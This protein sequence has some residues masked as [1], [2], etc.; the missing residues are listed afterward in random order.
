[1]V[2]LIDKAYFLLNWSG[3]GAPNLYP[4]SVGVFLDGLTGVNILLAVFNM[5]PAC[6]M[7]GGRILRGLLALKLDYARASAIAVFV[8]QGL[9]VIL[10][11]FRIFFNWRLALIGIFLYIGAGSEKQAVTLRSVLRQVHA[12]A[13][14]ETEIRTLRPEDFLSRPLEHIYRSWQD[15][16]QVF[17]DRG[18]EG[19]LARGRTLA[20][21]HEK[22][23]DI[24]VSE[25]MDRDFASIDLSAPLDEVYQK[26]PSS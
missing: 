8:G 17:G 15:D 12:S 18:M 4:D 24:P 14:M 1:M 23:V 21:I 7:D 3:I 22:G 5:V 9:V 11:F 20:A 16:F 2:I 26:L 19:I 6:P 25:V 13:A 10:V